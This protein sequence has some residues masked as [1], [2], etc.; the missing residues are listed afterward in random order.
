[1]PF[2]EFFNFELIHSDD[3]LLFLLF[4]LTPNQNFLIAVFQ[5][6][7][8]FSFVE[9]GLL[10]LCDSLFLKT[11][12]SLDLLSFLLDLF[13]FLLVLLLKKTVLLVGGEF[14]L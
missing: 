11:A 2:P 1:M 9:K 7:K 13:Q 12:F 14:F 8:L 3:F 4:G 5:L 10:G 6:S